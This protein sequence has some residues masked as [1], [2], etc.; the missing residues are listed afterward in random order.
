[1]SEEKIFEDLKYIIVDKLKVEEERIKPSS[2]L[3]D[4]LSADS[5]DKIEMIMELETLY[6][7]DIPEEKAEKF[8]TV[9]DITKYLYDEKVQD[10]T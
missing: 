10:T 6:D 2:S 3:V 9:N 8:K 1:M 4:D 7:I 5:L